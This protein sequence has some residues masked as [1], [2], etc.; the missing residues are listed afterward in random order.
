MA[1]SF[2]GWPSISR[3]STVIVLLQSSHSCLGIFIKSECIKTRRYI[4]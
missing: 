2:I 4:D 3:N 1:L